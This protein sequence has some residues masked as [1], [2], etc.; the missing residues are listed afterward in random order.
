MSRSPNAP[1]GR[2]VSL[3]VRTAAAA[4]L[5]LAVTA[6]STPAAPPP[7]SGASA[8]APAVTAN[9]GALTLENAQPLPI[10][11]RPD[12]FPPPAPPAPPVF[13]APTMM[14][15]PDLPR[16]EV[17]AS[18]PPPPMPEGAPPVPASARPAP[19]PPP[20][21]TQTDRTQTAALPPPS[22]GT[23]Q[24]PTLPRM[25]PLTVLFDGAAA[26][27]PETAQA[28]LD[29]I[30]ERMRA[31]GQ[32]RLQIRS[33]ASGTPETAREA[34]QLSL[35]RALSVRE[36]LGAAGIASTRVDIRAMG[37]EASG[38]APDRL[39]VEFLNQ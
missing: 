39:D 36:R 15:A 18:P 28:R 31:S 19:P 13:K 20:D 10:P 37:M 5:S 26:D 17:G 12:I 16:I 14:T 9:A 32:L 8:P 30:A 34:R 3:R 7:Q 11:P 6:C 25:E 27:L 35:A 1:A 29:A 38:G 21:R 24:P 22:P 33:Y 23:P 4:V 2:S